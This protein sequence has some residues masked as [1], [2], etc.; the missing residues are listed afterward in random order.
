MHSRTRVLVRI[1]FWGL[2]IDPRRVGSMSS[3]LTGHVDRS[4]LQFLKDRCPHP[5][6]KYPDSTMPRCCEIRLKPGNPDLLQLP[7]PAHVI[8]LRLIIRMRRPSD[9]PSLDLKVPRERQDSCPSQTSSSGSSKS[10]MMIP[11]LHNARSSG[12]SVASGDSMEE[13][14]PILVEQVA[15][16]LGHC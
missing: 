13:M 1:L 10:G 2:F 9:A 3:W 7:V 16:M 8:C 14:I 4:S 12:C 11:N 6:E 5:P 15:Q